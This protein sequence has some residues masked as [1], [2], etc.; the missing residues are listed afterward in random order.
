MYKTVDDVDWENWDPVERATLMFVIRDGK[1]LLMEA[2]LIS[3]AS[4]AGLGL[5]FDG[6]GGCGAPTNARK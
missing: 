5:D 3:P 6:T 2:A 1:I 4:G